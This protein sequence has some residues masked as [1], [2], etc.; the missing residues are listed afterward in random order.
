MAFRVADPERALVGVRLVQEAGIAADQLDFRRSASS[1]E[2]V[3]DRPLVSRLEYLLELRY[4]DGGSKVS[5]DAANPRQVRGAFGPK[6]VLEF[7]GYAPPAWLSAPAGRGISRTFAV[8]AL[9]DMIAVRV[10]S[11]AG[12]RDSEPLPL[13]VVHDGPEYDLLASL[14]RYLSAG[15]RG[16]WLPRLRA[17]LLSPGPRS[18]WYSANA[19]YARALR[20][21]ILPALTEHFGVSCRIGMGASLGGLAMLHAY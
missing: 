5:V 1:W 11:P 4:P 2:L 7:P 14:V 6:S 20:Q 12:G 18:N 17:A 13:L 9:D 16:G 21:F 19:R 8:P 3:L 10:W 15:I